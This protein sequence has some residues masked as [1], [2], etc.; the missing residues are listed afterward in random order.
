LLNYIFAMEEYEKKQQESER[1][2]KTSW[3]LKV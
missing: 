1:I 3:Q 2:N